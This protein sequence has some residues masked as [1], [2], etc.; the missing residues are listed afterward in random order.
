MEPERPVL[1]LYLD[2]RGLDGGQQ[3][4]SGGA[5]GDRHVELP[6]PRHLAPLPVW[7]EAREEELPAAPLALQSLD[8]PA[9]QVFTF[10]L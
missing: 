4:P 3:G 10:E 5:V 7:L 2:V 6:E 9:E 8:V 1:L